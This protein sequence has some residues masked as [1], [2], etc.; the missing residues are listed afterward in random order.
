MNE[1]KNNVGSAKKSGK[2]NVL[3]FLIIVVVLFVLASAIVI[4]IPKIQE[5]VEIGEKVIINYTVVFEGV[6]DRVYDKIKGNQMA[7]DAQSNRALGTVEQSEV[8]P[9][10]EY[11]LVRETNAE[12]ET[13][14]TAVKQEIAEK[15]K[16]V[17]VTITANAVYNEGSGYTV[18]GYRIAVGKE[19]D[20]RFADFTGTAYC[21]GVT[22]I[23]EG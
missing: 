15:G 8:A 3:D 4:T 5:S 13:V 20:I 11:V 22:V 19:M 10:S 16:N 14:Y 9:Y 21:T 12:G 1:N 6:N 17:T 18:D 23:N 2:F 7:M